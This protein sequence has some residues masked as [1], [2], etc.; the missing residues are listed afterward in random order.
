MSKDE[1][2]SRKVPIWV[3]TVIS[4][5]IIGLVGIV[6]SD[7]TKAIDSK[8]NKGEVVQF[9]QEIRTDVQEIKESQKEMVKFHMRQNK[10]E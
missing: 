1:L 6:Y 9:M 5:V 7:V 3:F 8:A 4:T 2:V 10:R